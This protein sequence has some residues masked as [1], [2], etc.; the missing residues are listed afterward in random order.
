MKIIDYQIIEC[1]S[2]SRLERE[3]KVLIGDGWQPLG[4]VASAIS[5][6]L[7]YSYYQAFVRYEEE[8]EILYNLINESSPSRLATKVR[9]SIDNGW[10]PL[11]GVQQTEYGL[12][13]TMTKEQK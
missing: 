12:I 13:Q 3:A 1:S 7:S 9:D 4:S 11:G 6:D 5:K 10:K 8:P 2:Y